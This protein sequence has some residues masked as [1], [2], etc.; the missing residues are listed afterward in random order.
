[1]RSCRRYTLSI[2]R[3][4][5]ASCVNWRISE[6]VWEKSPTLFLCGNYV[7]IPHGKTL[8]YCGKTLPSAAVFCPFRVPGI[9]CASTKTKKN[10]DITAFSAW[11]KRGESNPLQTVDISANRG[12]RGNSRGNSKKRLCNKF[13]E[14][15]VNF[16][17][18]GFPVG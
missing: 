17:I 5:N 9:A 18:C 11:W 12:Y 2:L 1:M 3:F 14:K 13:R 15:N 8:P 7:A 6:G 4:I 10:A 16:A